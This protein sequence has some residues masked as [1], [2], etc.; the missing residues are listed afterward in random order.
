[1]A[2]IDSFSRFHVQLINE[3]RELNPPKRAP[4]PKKKIT[5]GNGFDVVCRCSD[6]VGIRYFVRYKKEIIVMCKDWN[7]LIQHMGWI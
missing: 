4:R 5:L 3:A 2:S 6:D 7:R 1:M